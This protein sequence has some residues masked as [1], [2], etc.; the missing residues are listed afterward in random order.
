[1]TITT[2]NEEVH[3][4]QCLASI[5]EQSYPNV[6]VIVVDNFSTDKTKEIALE[7]GALFFSLGPERSAQRNFGMKKKSRGEFLLFLDADMILSPFL[8]EE[9]VKQL[10][11]EREIG[12]L[13][14]PEIVLGKNYLSAVRRFERRFYDGTVVDGA[15]FF[16]KE[17]FL[18]SGGFN[19][20]FSGPEDWDLDLEIKKI[21]AIG[22]LQAQTT[23]SSQQEQIKKEWP[24]FRFIFT[25]GV[26]PEIEGHVIYHNEAEFVLS[27]YLKKKK[28][29]AASFSA[30]I[31]KWGK[32]NMAIKKQFGLGYRFL[33]VF[34]ENGKWKKWIA[35]PDLVFGMYFLRFLVG[36]FFLFKSKPSSLV[37]R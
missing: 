15:R 18:A 36:S 25:R 30:Y 23:T 13:H 19:E 35:R 29:Y 12:A 16:R 17:I 24:L 7:N 22:L 3:L 6:E 10:Q 33:F 28:Y 37:N 32:S 8:I 34:L 31:A 9:C 27:R 1:V 11:S 14:I 5:R 26:R 4:S 2:K 20:T 21:T